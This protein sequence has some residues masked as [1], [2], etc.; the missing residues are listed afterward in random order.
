[1]TVW[2]NEDLAYIHDVGFRDYALKS[3][4]GIVEILKQHQIRAGL[5]VDLG[6]GSGLSAAILHQAGYQV[7]GIDISEAMIAIAQTR[8]PTVEF[9]VASL[10]T[11]EI[12][13]CAAIISIGECL[14]YAF[15]TNSDAALDSLFQR[16]YHALSPGGVFIFDVV[17]PGHTAPGEIVR[18]FTEGQD[19]IVLVEKQED[20]TQQ[21]LTRRI[22]TLRQ[23][24]DL[25]RRTEE[26]HCLRLF[27]RS[28]LADALRQKGF[29]VNISDC[30]GEFSLPP[31]RIAA[32]AYKPI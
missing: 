26:V 1:M 8:V 19:W 18:N 30:Y 32:I 5:I 15:D 29:Q 24:E 11:A 13:P 10:F 12:P 20:S 7:L 23:F 28:T 22:I 2:Y 4:P 3:A 21:M 25:Y 16:I 31:A 6:C 17:V 27:N 9:R 14:S